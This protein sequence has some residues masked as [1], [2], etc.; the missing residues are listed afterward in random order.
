MTAY[1]VESQGARWR[2]LA[3][4][5]VVAR[6]ESRADAERVCLALTL[7]DG[8]D[9]DRLRD[10]TYARS[11]GVLVEMFHDLRHLLGQ[12]AHGQDVFTPAL[13]ANLL[14]KLLAFEA[15]VLALIGPA[16]GS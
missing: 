5:R 13:S 3:S 10:G 16:E 4:G 8:L 12:A 11:L 1:A 14:A 9:T 7:A 6:T 2:V 15:D